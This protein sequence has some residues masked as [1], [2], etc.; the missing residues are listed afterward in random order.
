LLEMAQPKPAR[1]PMETREARAH[2][3][4]ETRGKQSGG[5]FVGFTINWGSR[6]GAAANRVLSHICRRGQIRGQMVG[7]I[8]VGPEE[9]R[10][11]VAADVASRFEKL[12]QRPDPREP[13]L[14]IQ[15]ARATQ[16]TDKR[17]PQAGR[18][19]KMP[20]KK[21]AAASRSKRR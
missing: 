21:S 10:F 7:A 5:D 1:A 18:G 16:T 14:R 9:S 3:E 15:R 13:K 19:G 11:D 20:W 6:S 17:G 2:E 12:V 8:K 4:R